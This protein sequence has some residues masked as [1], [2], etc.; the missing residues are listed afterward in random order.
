MARTSTGCRF[1]NRLLVARKESGGTRSVKDK[2]V[3]GPMFSRRHSLRVTTNKMK[4][5]GMRE[6][7]KER[8]MTEHRLCPRLF[9]GIDNNL[10]MT[11]VT[12]GPGR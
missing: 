5:R 4:K 2:Q 6:K 11:R 3:Q 7:E 10:I 12:Q 9:V 1:S 8:K